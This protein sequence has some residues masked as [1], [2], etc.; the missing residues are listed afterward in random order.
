[1]VCLGIDTSGETL[2]VGIS[3]GQ[4]IIGERFYEGKEPHSV[5]LIL[6]IETLLREASTDLDQLNL[7]AISGGPGRYTALRVGMAT[8]KG[9]A[10]AKDIPLVRVSA[11][12]ALA[13]S[14]LPHEGPVTT[15]LDARRHLVYMVNFEAKG[16]TL[17]EMEEEQALSYEEAVKRVPVG[18]V[19]TGNGV[20]LV[21]PLLQRWGKPYRFQPGVIHGGDVARLGEIAFIERPRNDLDGG[22]IYIRKV[23]I[24]NPNVERR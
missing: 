7:V 23:E 18:A 1:M 8:A 21:Q 3:F 4:K 2:S 10:M 15:I 11:L 5:R 20:P 22:P 14:L 16:Q 12:H 17:L 24:H 9:I 13:C 6:E 19:L